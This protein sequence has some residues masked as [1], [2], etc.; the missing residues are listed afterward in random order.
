MIIS[1]LC[2]NHSE[3]LQVLL[4]MRKTRLLTAA[5]G[6][7]ALFLAAAP[8]VEAGALGGGLIEMLAT[9]G[10]ASQS[11]SGQIPVQPDRR[12]AARAPGLVVNGP[13]YDPRAV[14]TAVD[15]AQVAREV[16]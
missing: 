3:P 13:A 7:L 10:L 5:Q 1:G 11:A 8:S 14:Q 12:L 15:P 4:A 2:L 16:A 6:G 9:G